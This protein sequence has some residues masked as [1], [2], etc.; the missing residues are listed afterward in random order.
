MPAPRVKARRAWT[1]RCAA[2]ADARSQRPLLPSGRRLQRQQRRAGSAGRSG[3]GRSGPV[4]GARRRRLP[5]PPQCPPLLARRRIARASDGRDDGGVDRQLRPVPEKQPVGH[6][7][8]P[9]SSWTGTSR[10]MFARRTLRTASR[11]GFLADPCHSTLAPLRGC[12]CR[13][14]PWGHGHRLRHLS[15][16]F[17]QACG[18]PQVEQTNLSTVPI[19]AARRCAISE[20]QPNCRAQKPV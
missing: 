4:C 17:R 11:A 12:P 3:S 2:P 6:D 13:P 20:S 14:C 18:I 10:F 9:A 5:G 8:D 16:R 7:F 19:G 1:Q 15:P